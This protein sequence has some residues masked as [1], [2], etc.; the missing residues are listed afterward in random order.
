MP[1]IKV[2]TLEVGARVHHELRVVE[3]DLRK[4]RN[5]DPFVVLTHPWEPLR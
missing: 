5:G 3:R 4:T 1:P 2:G